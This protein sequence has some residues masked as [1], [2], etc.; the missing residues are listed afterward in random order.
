M[1]VLKSMQNK[2]YNK[3]FED[4]SR[5]TR[6]KRIENKKIQNDCVKASAGARQDMGRGARKYSDDFEGC[7]V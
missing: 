6:N 3:V 7:M 4:C 1:K 5:S 2:M